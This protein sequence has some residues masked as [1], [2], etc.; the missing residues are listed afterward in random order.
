MPS[1]LKKSSNL[2]EENKEM[3]PVKRIKD[4]GPPTKKL[5]V[6]R[7]EEAVGKRDISPSGKATTIPV[8]SRYKSVPSLVPKEAHS[9]AH[10]DPLRAAQF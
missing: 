10:Q 7:K 3:G 5:V 4:F 8:M 2:I 6:G 9:G 1:S